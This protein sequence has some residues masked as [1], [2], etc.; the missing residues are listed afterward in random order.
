MLVHSSL[1][2]SG[3]SSCSYLFRNCVVFFCGLGGRAAGWHALV[4][5]CPTLRHAHMSFLLV[6][7]QNN[8]AKYEPNAYLSLTT[9]NNTLCM[10]RFPISN[11]IIPPIFFD[12]PLFLSSRILIILHHLL[13]S[14]PTVLRTCNGMTLPCSPRNGSQCVSP[15]QAS[16]LF[17]AGDWSFRHRY[18]YQVR[19]RPP[20][21]DRLSA[22]TAD[23]I[24]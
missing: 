19:D 13:F 7:S 22:I 6:N 9:T 8:H 23:H 3:S 18:T 14:H 15:D 1:F 4:P 16:R 5:R 2:R 10:K 17:E 21:S 24:K 11:T 12:G 20:F